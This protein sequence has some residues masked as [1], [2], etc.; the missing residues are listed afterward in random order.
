MEIQALLG[1]V[2]F[3]LTRGVEKECG[4]CREQELAI[5]YANAFWLLND[6]TLSM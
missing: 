4:F 1:R 2:A 3:P 6:I 5:I